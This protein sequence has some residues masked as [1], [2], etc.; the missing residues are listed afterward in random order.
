[1]RRRWLW[2]V[3]LTALIG[4]C[5]ENEAATKKCKGGS[6]SSDE[7]QK[8]CNENGASGYKYINGDCGCLGG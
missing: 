3:A 7:C 5:S 6:S 4:G 8:C 2:V 1:M